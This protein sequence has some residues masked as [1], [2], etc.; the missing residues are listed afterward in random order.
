LHLLR[1]YSRQRLN[2]PEVPRDHEVGNLA[3]KVIQQ[4]FRFEVLTPG[5]FD[6]NQYIIVTVGR[7][8][9]DRCAI[10]DRRVTGYLGLDFIRRDVFA[11]ASNVI[12]DTVDKNTVAVPIS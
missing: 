3:H 7:P 9:S 12:L 5:K 2:E 4:R 1:G 8:D 6:N 11:T 10:L